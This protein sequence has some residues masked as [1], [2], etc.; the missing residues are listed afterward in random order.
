VIDRYN[1]AAILV[2]GG[3]RPLCEETELNQGTAK[4]A[5]AENENPNPFI[6]TK[7]IVGEISAS[8]QKYLGPIVS[9]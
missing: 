3:G 8:M 7:R 1:E 2:H 6:R 5:K 9:E 4:W